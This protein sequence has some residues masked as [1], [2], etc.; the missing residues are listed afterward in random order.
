MLTQ[1]LIIE[2]ITII[3]LKDDTL[4]TSHKSAYETTCFI[5]T[6]C[7]TGNITNTGRSDYDITFL[8]LEINK[9]NLRH[10]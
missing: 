5:T 2:P 7:N 4:I 8:K 6:N 1:N 9:M 10:S 3:F